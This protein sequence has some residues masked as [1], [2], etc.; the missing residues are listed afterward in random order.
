[1]CV[2]LRP[3]TFYTRAGSWTRTRSLTRLST[4]GLKE[5]A[6]VSVQ[7]I[8]ISDVHKIGHINTQCQNIAIF[9]SHKSWQLYTVQGCVHTLEKLMA[10]SI[11]SRSGKAAGY[12]I[13]P[14]ICQT[15]IF[16]HFTAYFSMYSVNRSQLQT[17]CSRTAQRLFIRNNHDEKL[18]SH[19]LLPFFSVQVKTF[20]FPY[21][22]IILA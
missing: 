15:H 18:W 17:E 21:V 16:A 14:N 1:M 13:C 10:L 22:S 5:R 3:P 7:A 11:I 20:F 8:N 9:I 6:R 4:V 19:L 2:I 12:H